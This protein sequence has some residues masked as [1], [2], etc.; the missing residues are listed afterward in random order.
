MAGRR[1]ARASTAL[2]SLA[3]VP[4][5]R[6]FVVP[7]L[8][9]GVVEIIAVGYPLWVAFDLGDLGADT[10]LRTALPVGDRRVHRVARRDHDVAVAAVVGGRSRG[11]AASSVNKDLAAR[12]YRITLKGPVRVLLLRTGVW[13]GRGRADRPVPPHLRRL[14]AAA[15]R[16]ADRARG[17]PRVHRVVRA[18]GVVGADPRRGARRGC[19]R[20]ARRSSGSTT[21]TS[22]GSCSS[23]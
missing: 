8:V 13:T 5:K 21:V 11:A 2:S 18:R 4:F 10:L 22:A 3:A 17:G 14:A 9:L 1:A 16:R 12:A 15:R 7:A 6:R 20:S 19:S 23:R